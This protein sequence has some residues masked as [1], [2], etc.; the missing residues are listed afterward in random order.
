MVGVALCNVVGGVGAWVGEVGLCGRRRRGGH[1]WR[2]WRVKGDGWAI[3]FVVEGLQVAGSEVVES[4]I[5]LGGSGA[6]L[7]SF[8]GVGGE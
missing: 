2:D 5:K 8:V 1:G 3:G 7:S 4:A 6:L